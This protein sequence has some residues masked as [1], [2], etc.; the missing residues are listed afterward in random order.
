MA[1]TTDLE[2]TEALDVTEPAQS[3]DIAVH[4]ER[5]ID[6]LITLDRAKVLFESGILPKWVDRP[7]KAIVAIEYARE[8]KLPNLGA[9]KNMYIVNGVPTIT[10]Y[11]MCALIRASGG[12]YRFIQD[13]E[14][15]EVSGL[16]DVITT[17][18]AVRRE[19]PFRDENGRPIVYRVSFTWREAELQ[20]LTSKDNWK[21]MPKAMLKARCLSK[22]AREVFPDVILGYYSPDEIDVTGKYTYDEEGNILSTI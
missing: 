14:K 12:S 17:V 16:P 5:V 21:K 15:I 1:T 4:T 13:A 20:Q 10:T 2:L 3:T 8:L 22:M 7:E 18:E 9:L 19:D 6:G 11:L